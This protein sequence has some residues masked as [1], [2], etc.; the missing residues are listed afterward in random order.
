MKEEKKEEKKEVTYAE[1]KAKHGL[2]D[3]TVNLEPSSICKKCPTRPRLFTMNYEINVG[4]GADGKPLFL[5][6]HDRV[7]P[8]CGSL[9]Q[10]LSN[11]KE[12]RSRAKQEK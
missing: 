11:F 4:N 1:V 8:M 3:I 2:G 7:C 10:S 5:K 9:E 12:V 6:M